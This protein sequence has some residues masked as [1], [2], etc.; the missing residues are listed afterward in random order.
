MPKP[1]EYL[2]KSDED[3]FV[4]SIT[5]SDVAIYPEVVYCKIKARITPTVNKKDYVSDSKKIKKEI[6]QYINKIINTSTHYSR[7]MCSVDLTDKNLRFKKP[8][9]FKYEIYLATLTEQHLTLSEQQAI[10]KPMLFLINS[11]IK[12]LFSE[13]N[14]KF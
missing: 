7:V 14:F 4:T 12:T 13:F 1:F 10:L 6:L 8:S 2:Y 5:T 3:T 11:K 9:F